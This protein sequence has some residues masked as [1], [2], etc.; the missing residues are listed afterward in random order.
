[1]SKT[2]KIILRMK[3][4]SKMSVM[5]CFLYKI[6]AIDKTSEL[7]IRLIRIHED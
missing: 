2:D 4:I 1:M 7:S 5:Y 3:L 6:D